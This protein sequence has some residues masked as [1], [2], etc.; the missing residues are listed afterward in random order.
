MRILL[1][2]D[3]L[4]CPRDETLVSNTW[5]DRILC[6][7]SGKGAVIYT[8]CVHGL[9]ASRIDVEYL[10]EIRPDVIIMQIGIVDACRR[11]LGK[12]E[13]EIVSRIPLIGN[14]AKKICG[15]Y[16]YLFSTIRNVH[17]CSRKKFYEV[18]RQICEES[19][20]KVFFLKIAAPGS[21]LIKKVY[22]VKKDV[23]VYNSIAETIPKLKVV[24]PYEN[25]DPDTFLLSDGH[26][27]NSLGN[28]LLYK[29]VDDLISL[30]VKKKN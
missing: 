28:E 2:T 21:G 22:N 1:L 24:D 23:L 18:V 8:C 20:G 29:A 12:Y 7:W 4:G 5:V 9:S 27:L 10:R 19:I 6:K 30:E 11:A 15:K 16:H 25:R 14:V 13:Y 26:H 17:Y 3:S